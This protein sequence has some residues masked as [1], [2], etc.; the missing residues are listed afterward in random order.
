MAF[1]KFIKDNLVLMTG[2]LLPIA[3]VI[4]FVIASSVPRMMTT[5]PAHDFI[6]VDNNHGY[7][8]NRVQTPIRITLRANKDGK[9]VAKIKVE[10]NKTNY[11]PIVYRY[12]AKDNIARPLQAQYFRDVLEEDSEKLEETKTLD[13]PDFLA[14][15]KLDKNTVAPDGFAFDTS[16]E[17]YNR[18]L[19]GEF[20]GRNRRHKTFRLVKGSAVF[21]FE[22]IANTH[23]YYNYYSRRVD[24]LGWVI[25]DGE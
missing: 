6:F 24:F 5:P 9:I 7:Y 25:E 3:L 4:L 23:R 17:R 21:P 20:F 22:V 13:M 10:K 2:I 16:S 11:Y 1:P 12:S 14:G 8:D 18:G 15:F 19:V